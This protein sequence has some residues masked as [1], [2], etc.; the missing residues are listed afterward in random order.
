MATMFLDHLRYLWPDLNGLFVPG[1]LAFPLFCTAIAANVERD[2]GGAF[3]NARHA[4]YLGWMLV[5]AALSE[6]P[7]QRYTGLGHPYN[8]MPTLA[9]GL[10]IAWGLKYRTRLALTF[11]GAAV[12]VAGVL[13]EERLMYGLCGALLPAAIWMGLHGRAAAWLL[14]SALSLA[15]NLREMARLEPP[16]LEPFMLLVAASALAGPCLGLWL[17]RRR[18]TFRVPPVRRWGYGFY[19]LHL[20]GLYGFGLFLAWAQAAGG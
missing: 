1:R 5:F 10:V 3:P 16:V 18:P 6:W 8:V 9:L 7:Y 20:F 15:P 4:R 14:A 2:D 19:P 17:L 11:A 12:L 13:G